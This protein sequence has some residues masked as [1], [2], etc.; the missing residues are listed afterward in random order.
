MAGVD[1]QGVAAVTPSC[2]ARTL[3]AS[4][5]FVVLAAVFAW[6][7][8]RGFEA[9]TFEDRRVLAMNAGEIFAR[10]PVLLTPERQAF[11]ARA[12]PGDAAEVYLV[13]FIYTSCPTLCQVLGSEF[14]QMQQRLKDTGLDSSVRLLSVSIDLRRDEP[15]QLANYAKRHQADGKTWVVGVPISAR[16]LKTV[17]RDLQV[18]AVDDGFGGYVHNG[19]IHMLDASGNLLGLYEYDQWQQAVEDASRMVK[20]SL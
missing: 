14:H 6:H 13:D 15:E 4:A 8:T 17:L 18:V 7:L 16:E 2:L 5:I 12:Q 3:V 10:L 19:A 1:T 9:W 11:S 20:A